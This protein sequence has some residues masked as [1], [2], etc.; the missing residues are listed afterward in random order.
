M[1]KREAKTEIPVNLYHEELH[2]PRAQEVPGSD[3]AAL[4]YNRFKLSGQEDS[5][6]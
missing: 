6:L 2:L 5:A 4:L 3:P 1:A